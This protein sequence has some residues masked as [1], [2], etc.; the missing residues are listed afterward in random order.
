MAWKNGRPAAAVAS[1]FLPDGHDAGLMTSIVATDNFV[2]AGGVVHVTGS[3]P[4][5]YSAV[6]W[7][8]DLDLGAVVAQL[9]PLP[10]GVAA[11]SFGPSVDVQVLGNVLL[12]TTSLA[13]GAGLDK[14]V[15]WS[16]DVP[17]AL[18]GLDFTA[19]PYGSSTGLRLVSG[20]PYV[21]GFV[22]PSG[23]AGL[24]A[25]ALWGGTIQEILSTVDPSLGLG[26]AEALAILSG[27]AYVSGETYLAGT[28]NGAPFVSVPAWWDNGSRSDL[29]GLVPPGGGPTLSE[30][31]F[32]WWRVPGTPSTARPDWPYAGGFAEIDA[33]PGGVAAAGSGVAKAIGVVPP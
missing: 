13:T 17:L 9:V 31:L 19:G 3:S 5:A 29:A 10:A 25:P 18:L 6:L 26:A 32:G 23:A 21:S 15:V 2:V 28:G 12:S 7:V 20:T 24:P 33:A 8:L 22:R 4:P 11:A 27:H 16:D 30:P 14:P 1:R